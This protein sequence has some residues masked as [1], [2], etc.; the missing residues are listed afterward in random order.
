[1][2]PILITLATAAEVSTGNP[3]KVTPDIQEHDLN[4]AL[5][6]PILITLVTTAGVSGVDSTGNP[7]KVTP[8]VQK[9]ER[10]RALICR[11]GHT[12]VTNE[13]VFNRTYRRP[14]RV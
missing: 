1:M 3:H 11:L 12:K 5:M 6:S 9:Q 13:T 2:S 8:D 14:G 7:H 4:R 10:N